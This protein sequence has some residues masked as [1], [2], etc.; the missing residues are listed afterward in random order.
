MACKNIEFDWLRVINATLV[1]GTSATIVVAPT[2]LEHG[3]YFKLRYC[4]KFSDATGAEPLLLSI[5]GVIYPALDKWGNPVTIGM[6][7]RRELL[8]MRFSNITTTTPTV[9]PHFTLFNKLFC[10]SIVTPEI[11]TP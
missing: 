5:A 3:D 1:Q 7:R 11:T 10:Q 9:S 2:A 6:L 8:C 4:V